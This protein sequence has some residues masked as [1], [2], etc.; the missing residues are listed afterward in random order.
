M[1]SCKELESSEESMKKQAFH[2]YQ[3]MMDFD[4]LDAGGVV[5]HPNYLLLCERAR[6]RALL[7]AHCSLQLLWA[8]QMTVAISECTCKY[9][10][11]LVY[12]QKIS[13]MTKL[14]QHSGAR[15][16]IQQYFVPEVS[17][18]CGFHPLGQE[19]QGIRL[20]EAQF[21][22]VVVKLPSLKITRL[23]KIMTDAL[24]LHADKD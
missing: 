17:W 24:H 9:F 14:L 6:T 18:S 13:V 16:T 21:L 1:L 10:Q 11:P 2:V 5:H 7:D 12:E 20:F 4:L 15:L 3:A 23:P 19:P 22:L 8:S